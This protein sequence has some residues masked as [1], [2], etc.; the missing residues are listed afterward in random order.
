ME[1]TTEFLP[2]R[3][4]PTNW[5]RIQWMLVL[6]ASVVA[7]F[8]VL[9]AT[10]WAW[11]LWQQSSP[12]AAV[13]VL[14]G[15]WSMALFLVWGVRKSRRYYRIMQLRFQRLQNTREPFGM[16]INN[17]QVRLVEPLTYPNRIL[18]CRTQDIRDIQLRYK[19]GIE[20]VVLITAQEPIRLFPHLFEKEQPG[21][22]WVQYLRQ[23]IGA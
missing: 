22:K 7:S 12:A 3:Y 8:A 14:S 17:Q 13:L 4:I 1:T 5:H 11:R 10:A 6:A 9:G 16:W 15:S 23:R 20:Q 2:I 18:E 21:E 19:N